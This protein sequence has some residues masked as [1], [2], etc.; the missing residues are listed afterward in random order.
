MNVLKVDLHVHV[1]VLK[2]KVK[3][4]QNIQTKNVKFVRSTGRLIRVSIIKLQIGCYDIYFFKYLQKNVIILH[5][6][7]VSTISC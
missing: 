7:G 3:H 5:C 6:S 1:N 4:C 2:E